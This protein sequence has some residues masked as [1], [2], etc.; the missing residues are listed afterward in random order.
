MLV[1]RGC[2]KLHV[3]PETMTWIVM[4]QGPVRAR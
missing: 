3:A 1:G 4:V 2:W